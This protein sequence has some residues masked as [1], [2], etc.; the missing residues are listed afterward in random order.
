MLVRFRWENNMNSIK[1]WYLRNY[2]EITWFMI[3]FLIATALDSFGK[4][5]YADAVF[6]LVLAFAN[7][8]LNKK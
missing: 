8:Y 1:Q 5:N 7:Y 4:G 6:S 3:G 2:T